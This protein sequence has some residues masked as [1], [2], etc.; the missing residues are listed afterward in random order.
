VVGSEIRVAFLYAGKYTNP[1][2]FVGR[3]GTHIPVLVDDQ[4]DLAKWYSA[5]LVYE[6]LRNSAVRYNVATRKSWDKAANI[7]ALQKAQKVATNVGTKLVTDQLKK[8][9]NI[10]PLAR[11]SKASERPVGT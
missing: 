6:D 4:S 8:W 3:F 1:S 9:R 10:S 7:S 5:M 11:S 2:E